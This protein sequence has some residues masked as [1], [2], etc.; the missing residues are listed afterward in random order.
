MSE[1]TKS[2]LELSP[3]MNPELAQALHN[4]RNAIEKL[5]EVASAQDAGM[6]ENSDR[7]NYVAFHFTAMYGSNEG[8]CKITQVTHM[9]HSDMIH[10]IN[11]IKERIFDK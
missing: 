8:V 6:K 7:D 11:S 3:N 10:I 2:V 5:A 1:N 4:V 9:S